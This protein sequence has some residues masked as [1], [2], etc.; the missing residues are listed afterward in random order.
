MEVDV[1]AVLGRPPGCFQELVQLFCL[2]TRRV[3]CGWLVRAL[4]RAADLAEQA[5]QEP[6]S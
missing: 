2:L 5:Q 4:K 1:L 6:K 3:F